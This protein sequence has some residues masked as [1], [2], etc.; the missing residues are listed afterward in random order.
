M[1]L[2]YDYKCAKEATGM[3]VREN[4]VD[5]WSDFLQ[6]AENLNGNWLVSQEIF[7]KNIVPT[8]EKSPEK[9]AK[10]VNEMVK[11]SGTEIKSK[12]LYSKAMRFIMTYRLFKSFNK[13]SLSCAIT[14]LLESGLKDINYAQKAIEKTNS[15]M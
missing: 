5:V 9:F 7:N 6:Y 4:H 13:K 8:A 14:E 2:G 10:W 11:I 15:E 12:K 1:G 3:V